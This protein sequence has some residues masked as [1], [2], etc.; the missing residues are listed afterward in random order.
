MFASQSRGL[1]LRSL[2]VTWVAVAGRRRA[3]PTIYAMGIFAEVP[4]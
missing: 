3:R 1:L 4:N 2:V